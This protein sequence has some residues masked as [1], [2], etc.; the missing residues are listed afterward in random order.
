M[1][2]ML[3]VQPIMAMDINLIID[4]KVINSTPIQVDGVT[5]VPARVVSE[6][7]GAEVSWD[8]ETEGVTISKDNTEVK[9]HIGS[10]SATVNSVVTELSSSPII[11]EDTT[12][13]PLRFVAEALDVVLRF[14]YNDPFRLTRVMLLL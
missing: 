12:M 1:A 13:V 4:D 14:Y 7:L 2:M 5:L 10:N 8:A 11:Q 6:Q 9:L 3:A